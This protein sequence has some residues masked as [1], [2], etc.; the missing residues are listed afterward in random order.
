MTES[1]YTTEAIARALND[2][3]ITVPRLLL[4]SLMS[5][6]LAGPTNGASKR[7]RDRLI[8]EAREFLN[9]PIQ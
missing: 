2:E 4:H 9:R 7:G 1:E 3:S 5:F 6:A 8:A